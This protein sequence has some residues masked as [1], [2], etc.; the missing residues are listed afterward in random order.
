MGNIGSSFIRKAYSSLGCVGFPEELLALLDTIRRRH[1]DNWKDTNVLMGLVFIGGRVAALRPDC[2][3]LAAEMVLS[4][5]SDASRW[6]L[7]IQRVLSSL[8]PNAD[9]QEIDALRV[10]LIE[11]NICIALT[12]PMGKHNKVFMK[13]LLV[14]CP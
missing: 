10:K 13:R 12:F 14:L 2:V 9:R 11:V 5:R 6:S 8:Q 3:D 7:D 4:C 1:V